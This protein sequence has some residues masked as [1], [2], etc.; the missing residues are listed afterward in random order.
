[1]IFGIGIDAIETKRVERLLAETQDR[2]ALK[3]FTPEEIAYCDRK[4]TRALHYAARFAAKEAFMKALGTGRQLG[5]TWKD[6]EVTHDSR[7]K[8]ELLLHG[9]AKTLAKEH[10]ITRLHLSLTHLQDL[11]IAVVILEK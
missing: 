7:G 6:V 1:M 9:R 10:G 11:A 8:P 4:K 3:V 2:F 5:V